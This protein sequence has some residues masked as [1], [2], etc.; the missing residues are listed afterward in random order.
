MKFH[1]GIFAVHYRMGAGDRTDRRDRAWEMCL[2]MT[3]I[4]WANV[5]TIIA[6]TAYL[7]G[8]RALLGVGG[9]LTYLIFGA[10][11]LFWI[12]LYLRGNR[13]QKVIKEFDE[14]PPAAKRWWRIIGMTY[15]TLTVLSVMSSLL[16]FA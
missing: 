4:S 11:L 13:Y 10:L 5:L 1:N 2:L 16:L 7:T 6:L 12:W 14:L 15:D 9:K 3:L 8:E